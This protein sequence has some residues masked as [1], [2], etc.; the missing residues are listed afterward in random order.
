MAHDPLR[1]TGCGGEGLVA[2]LDW[3]AGTSH[4]AG[5]YCA[6]CATA[7][8]TMLNHLGDT[9]PNIYSIPVDPD[10]DIAEHH[11]RCQCPEC[12]DLLDQLD[13]IEYERHRDE[14]YAS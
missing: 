3:Y 13:D 10:E 7:I 1:C 6:S 4:A 14:R 5:H 11:P 12:L 2:S 8:V 9:M